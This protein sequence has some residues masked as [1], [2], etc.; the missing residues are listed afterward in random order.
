MSSGGNG[1]RPLTESE[2]F[3]LRN[4]PYAYSPILLAAKA[5]DVARLKELRKNGFDLSMTWE[6]GTTGLHIAAQHNKLDA[7][8]YLLERGCDRASKMV[9]GY[10]RG[11]RTALELAE[12]EEFP[13]VVQLLKTWE[14][15]PGGPTED[16]DT[17]EPEEYSDEE[18]WIIGPTAK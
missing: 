14:P 15:T 13:E 5:G 6:G 8:K 2:W 1:S 4:T 12:E 16:D 9:S 17:D 18:G 10:S 3:E 7:T 11:G